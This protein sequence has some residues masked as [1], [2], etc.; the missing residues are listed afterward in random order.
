MEK[1]LNNFESPEV[2]SGRKFPSSLQDPETSV[3]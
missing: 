1:Y 2:S 3:D